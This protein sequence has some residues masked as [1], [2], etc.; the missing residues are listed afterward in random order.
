LRADASMGPAHPSHRPQA[1]AAVATIWGR[2][3]AL[4]LEH[5]RC[6][7]GAVPWAF[8]MIKPSDRVR[9]QP[10]LKEP[11]VLLSHGP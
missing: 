5:R 8:C 9:K 3:F 10:G 7:Q 1:L 2:H 11:E 6:N 4:T